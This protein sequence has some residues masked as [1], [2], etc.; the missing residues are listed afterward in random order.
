LLGAL[1]DWERN[2]AL[3]DEALTGAVTEAERR[4]LI[5]RITARGNLSRAPPDRVRGGGRL[6]GRDHHGFLLQIGRSHDFSSMRPKIQFH[7]SG[8]HDPVT[9]SRRSSDGAL[10]VVLRR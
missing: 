4:T 2:H 1:A 7:V 6:P 8:L 3:P 9:G 5:A 10:S